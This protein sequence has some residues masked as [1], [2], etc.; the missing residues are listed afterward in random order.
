[1]LGN[2]ISPEQGAFVKGRNIFENVTLKQVEMTKLLHRK[3][4]GRRNIMLKINMSKAY[5]QMN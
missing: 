2:I 5:D 4:R 1:M 3:V